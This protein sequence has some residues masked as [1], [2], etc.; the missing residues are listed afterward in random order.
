MKDWEHLN[1]MGL[2]ERGIYYPMV[3]LVLVVAI[4]RHVDGILI[5]PCVYLT[6]SC[7]C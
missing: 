2:A 4:I 6:H 5:Y 1:S 3:V 7:L